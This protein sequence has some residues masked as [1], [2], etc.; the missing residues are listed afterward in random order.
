MVDHIQEKNR[1]GSFILQRKVLGATSADFAILAENPSRDPCP[2]FVGITSQ[3]TQVRIDFQEP[4]GGDGISAAHVNYPPSGLQ[5]MGKAGEHRIQEH[6]ESRKEAGVG[7]QVS[8]PAESQ[9]AMFP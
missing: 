3:K 9:P 5:K 2:P 4:S 8:V 6:L 1:I 7:L